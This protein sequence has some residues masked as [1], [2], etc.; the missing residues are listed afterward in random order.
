M[1]LF[2]GESFFVLGMRT[3][4]GE[5][6]SGQI[7][8]RRTSSSYLNSIAAKEQRQSK[9][10]KRQKCLLLKKSDVHLRRKS[11]QCFQRPVNMPF[12]P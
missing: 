8:V 7:K 6:F 9:Q 3:T 4:N 5:G 2:F 12:V 1:P 10:N 11:N